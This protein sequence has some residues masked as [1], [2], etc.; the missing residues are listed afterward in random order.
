MNEISEDGSQGSDDPEEEDEEDEVLLNSPDALELLTPMANWKR[1]HDYR[2]IDPKFGRSTT[3][4]NNRN[5][6]PKLG[7][8][9]LKPSTDLQVKLGNPIQCRHS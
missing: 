9:V 7:R 5:L 3:K 4:L 1:V 8:M 6:D 2:N